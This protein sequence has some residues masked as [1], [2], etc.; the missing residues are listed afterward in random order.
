MSFNLGTKVRLLQPWRAY[1]AGAILEQGYA[2]DLETLVKAG[3]AE[4]VEPDRPGKMTRKAA[5]KIAAGVKGLFGNE[6][7]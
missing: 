3:I 1:S 6:S 7:R 2:A 4:E 5:E